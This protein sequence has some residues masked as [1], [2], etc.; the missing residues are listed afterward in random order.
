MA[1]RQAQTSTYQLPA[2][3]TEDVII[4]LEWDQVAPPT[5]VEGCTLYLEA[6]GVAA[7]R[8]D[9]LIDPGENKFKFYLSRGTRL[10]LPL[11]A[12][13]VT[14]PAGAVPALPD[15]RRASGVIPQREAITSVYS[16]LNQELRRM[17]TLY[18]TYLVVVTGGFATLVS[19]ADVIVGAPH[20]GLM[21]WALVLLALIVSYLVWQVASRYT[22]TSI[23]IENL[24]T[25]LG[26]REGAMAWPLLVGAK[27]LRPF[28]EYWKS[29]WTKA[30]RWHT[31]WALLLI[32]YTVALGALAGA[33]LIRSKVSATSSPNTQGQVVQ[34]IQMVSPL[35]QGKESSTTP[36][37]PAPARKVKTTPK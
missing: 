31:V 23:S 15:I 29:L 36:C 27:P 20:R 4:A 22:R 30:T 34:T 33:F 13:L 28:R 1:L 16:E 37:K 7:R 12:K 11:T 26:L 32:G 6:V 9:V 5:V 2:V 19:K 25:S 8:I 14:N 21:G 18:E 24:E 10:T 17:R 35:P 3:L